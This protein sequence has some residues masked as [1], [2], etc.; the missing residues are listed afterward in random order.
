VEI[1]DTA[2]STLAPDAADDVVA[3]AIRIPER[4]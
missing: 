2:V 1:V 3:F 4:A